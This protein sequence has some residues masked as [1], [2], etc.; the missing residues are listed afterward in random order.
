MNLQPDEMLSLHELG[1]FGLIERLSARLQ[2]R[3]GV[4]LGIGDDAAV[5][6]ALHTPIVTTDMMVENVHFRRDWISPRALGRKAMATNVSDLAAMGARPV[7]AF[8]NLALSTPLL[9]AAQATSWIDELY[10]G[11]E[12]AAAEYDFTVAGGDTTRAAH[13]I[14]IGVTLI[15]EALASE[16]TPL[17]RSG[18][19]VGDALVV[20][21]TL[22]DSAAGLW[23]LQHPK[24]SVD[25]AARAYLAGHHFEPR[26]RLNEIRAALAIENKGS[27]ASSPAISAALDL[28]D[29]LAGDALHIARRSG[30][31]LEIE[32]ARL[33]LSEYS[34]D[35]AQIA[36]QS[37]AEVDALDWALHGGEDYELLLCVA[38]ERAD[39]VCA[40]ITNATSTPATVIGRCIPRDASTPVVL[41]DAD[42]KRRNIGGAWQ[43][44]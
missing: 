17:L 29:G 9:G 2:N 23:L 7:A 34:R 26:A 32:V 37:G 39:E 4:R 41:V 5:L 16:S 6:N 19:R 44:F 30:V 35:A 24:I 38:A 12:D 28:S 11:F 21:G 40:A 22:G 25:A 36:K 14:T 8:V 33:P 15:G 31:S 43:H 20:T 18:A 27:A 13:E 10:A 42:G 3:P 1:E